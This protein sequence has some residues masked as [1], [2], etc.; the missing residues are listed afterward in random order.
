MFK[1]TVL[2]LTLLAAGIV[3]AEKEVSWKDL[4][5]NMDE[6]AKGPVSIIMTSEEKTVFPKLKTPEEKLQFIK[7]FWARRDPILRTRANEFKDEFFK[8]VEHANQTFAEKEIPGWKTAR[9]QVYVIF[10]PPS[11]VDHQPIAESSRPALLWVYDKLP[12]KRIPKNEALMFIWRDFKYVLAPP[13]PETGDAIAA[14]QASLDSS[15]RYQD[16][17]SM[18]NMAFADVSKSNVVDEKI[19]YDA[20]LF[21]VRST[22][23]FGIA[24]I[25]FETQVSESQPPQIQVNIPAASA[26]VYDEGTR[27][28]AEL[29]FVQ[30]LKKGDQVIAKN[31]HSESFTWSGTAFDDLNQI[32]VKLPALQAPAGSYELHVTVQ[33]RIS[34]VSETKKVPVSL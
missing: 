4:Q 18:V 34:G 16:I 27:K 26:P 30:E 11:R 29:V 33:D 23:K 20:L 15:F 12:A 19:H 17:P 3:Y 21:S 8:R 6:W 25:N 14:Q 22:E 7:L 1:K 24:A 2:I 5:N 13:N 32:N 10:G 9:G 31:E 28:F